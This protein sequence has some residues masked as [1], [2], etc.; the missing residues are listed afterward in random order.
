MLNRFISFFMSVW[1]VFSSLIS[2]FFPVNEKLRI[3]VPED[4]EL[5]VGDSRT[6]ECVFS[7]RITNRKL[8]WSTNPESVAA[9]DKWGRVTALSVGKATVT[10]KGNGFSD[11]VELNV[12]STPTLMNKPRTKKDFE[13]TPVKEIR[14]LQKLVSRF[15]HGAAQ[16]PDYVASAGDYINCQKA[17]TAD[18]AIWEITDYGVL[19]TDINAS[20]VRD[21]EQRFMGDRYFY[22]SDTTNGKVLAIFPD[23]QYGIWTVMESGVTHIEMIEADGRLKASYMSGI[24]Q[25][26][27]SRHGLINEAIL[28]NGSW[29]ATESDNDGLWTSMYGAGELMRYATLRNDPDATANEISAAKSA[30]YSA[31]EAVLMLYYISMRSGTTQAYVR[32]QTTETI[33]GTVN[34]RWLSADALEMGGDPS[35]MIP[36]KSPA[37]LY[38]EAMSTYT[39][40]SSSSKL[41]NDGF[42]CAVSPDDWSDPADNPDTEYEKQTRLLEGFPARTFRLKK[43]R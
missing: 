27:V 17:I 43:E 15:P 38:N 10:A 40:F 6:L 18:G 34:D 14:N 21:V 11:S 1:I 5:C 25:D 39:L 16:I 9:V 3:V 30:A 42:Y 29:F 37:D 4:W 35:V 13:L 23:G 8:E 26:N 7:E 41:E 36:A 24:T 22:S 12:V 31:S 20:T 32:R 33:P 19:R 28:S 2:G